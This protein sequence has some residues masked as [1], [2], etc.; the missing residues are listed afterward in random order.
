MSR[1]EYDGFC[2]LPGENEEELHISYFKFNEP[3]QFGAPIEA[4]DI[5]DKYH[6]AF[7]KKDDVGDPTFDDSFESIF[8]DPSV[9]IKNLVGLNL[10][11]CVLR[12]TEGSLEWWEDYLNKAKETCVAIKFKNTCKRILEVKK[13]DEL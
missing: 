1:E 13:E 9:Y 10:Y 8:L 3:G 4:S 2:F 11:G 12:K 5:G 6:I 7:F